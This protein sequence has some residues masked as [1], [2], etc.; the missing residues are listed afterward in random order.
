MAS[1]ASLETAVFGLLGLLIAFTFSGALTRFDGRRDQVVNEANAVGTAYL[2][3]DLLPPSAQPRLR[4]AFRNYLDARIATY[5]KLPDL[6]AAQQELTRSQAL[7]ADIWA[8]AVAATRLPESRTG[9]D[10]L[11]MPALNQM[12]DITTTRLAATQMHPPITVFI[13]LVGLALASALLIGLPVCRREER[14]PGP[15]VRIRGHRRLHRLRDPRH[16]YPR[17]GFIRIDAIDQVLLDVRASMI[18]LQRRFAG[19]T[20]SVRR[21]DRR[22]PQLLALPIGRHEVSPDLGTGLQLRQVVDMLADMD[23]ARA[24]IGG[25]QLHGARIG[26]DREH[27][28]D[29][30]LWRVVDAA[31]PACVVTP[32]SPA[33]WATTGC[34]S[35][36]ASRPKQIRRVSAFISGPPC[37]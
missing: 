15:R 3:I 7:Q 12:F 25:A 28:I 6:Q 4:E 17:L 19:R 29:S 32:P 1:T 21:P 13:M 34:N 2:R 22:R 14:P 8:Q 36:A 26:I 24:P 35:V 27:G 9:T 18:A 10:V 37:V 11:L 33:C 30:R 5:Q 16:Q 31:A 20:A 23:V